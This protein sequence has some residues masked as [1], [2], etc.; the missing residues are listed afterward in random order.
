MI[1]DLGTYSVTSSRMQDGAGLES[2]VL[3][4]KVPELPD[5]CHGRIR[6]MFSQLHGLVTRAEPGD[7]V[8]ADAVRGL[9]G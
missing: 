4:S 5:E 2:A 8:C 7:Q 1:F 3:V 6:A 9:C